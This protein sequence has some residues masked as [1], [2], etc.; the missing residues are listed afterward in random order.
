M[1]SLVDLVK[2]KQP[3]CV[4]LLAT[5]KANKAILV[6]GVTQDLLD[7]DLSAHNLIKEVAKVMNGSG[8]GRTDFARAAGEIDKIEAGFSRL[9]EIIKNLAVNR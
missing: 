5:D 4:S 1:R 9:R 7:K 3:R 8:G 6:M 2:K